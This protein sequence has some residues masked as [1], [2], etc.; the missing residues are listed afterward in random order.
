MIKKILIIIAIIMVQH[1]NAQLNQDS[2]AY[3]FDFN[4]KDGLLLSFKDL[5]NNNALPFRNI[6]TKY[7]YRKGD[8]LDLLLKE[9]EIRFFKNGKKQ[10]IPVT[11][12]W[13]Y[14]NKSHIYIQFNKK[15]YRIPSVGSISFFMANIEVEYQR[16]IDNWSGNTYGG[17]YG[18]ESYKSNELRRF[19]VDF[20]D[21]TIYDYTIRNIEK[22]ISKDKEIY[23]IFNT[24]RKRQ[25]RKNAFIYIKKYNDANPW[26]IYNNKK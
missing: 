4:F 7:D 11:E 1:T 8:F 10:I 6:I 14:V 17:M 18:T 20:T 22:L 26:Y 23:K 19:L 3:S 15:F 9:K 12:I 24:L 13:A 16:S 5:K 21:G 2:I 25:K